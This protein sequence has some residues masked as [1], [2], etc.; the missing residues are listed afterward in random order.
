MSLTGIDASTTLRLLGE[1]AL[2][3]DIREPGD[4]ARL[5][6]P[7]ALHAPLSE[8][9]RRIGGEGTRAVVFVCPAGIDTVAHGA[10]LMQAA[11]GAPAYSLS[12]GLEAWRAAGQ[13][14][15]ED[16]QAPIEAQRQL[17]LAVGALIL[18]SFALSHFVAPAFEGIELLLAAA[19]LT[20]GLTGRCRLLAIL[21]RMPWNRGHAPNLGDLA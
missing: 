21:A 2:L 13:P 11:G 18:A 20:G 19:L 10:R 8:L 6:V 15:V 4:H 7:G 3:V 17:L 5:R 12:G 14:V 16:R 1:G 9:P